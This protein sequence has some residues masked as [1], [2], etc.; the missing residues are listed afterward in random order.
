MSSFEELGFAFRSMNEG[1]GGLRHPDTGVGH[2]RKRRDLRLGAGGTAPSFHESAR[3]GS[4][5]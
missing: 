2:W 3:T 1:A 4:S 5:K